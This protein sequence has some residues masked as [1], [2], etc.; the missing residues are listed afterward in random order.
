LN[1][2]IHSIRLAET[3]KMRKLE[4]VERVL[5]PRNTRNTRPESEK[6][7]GGKAETKRQKYDNF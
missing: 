7:E 4:F 3:P 5:E 1:E 6:R 2:K